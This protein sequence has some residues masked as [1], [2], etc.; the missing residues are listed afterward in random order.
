M[1]FKRSK[2]SKSKVKKTFFQA[3][4]L[5]N[6]KKNSLSQEENH[7]ISETLESYQKALLEKNYEQ[8][9]KC[10]EKCQGFFGTHLKQS[11]IEKF[12]KSTLGLVGL[13]CV[14]IVVRQMWFEFNEIPTGSM[15]PTLLEKDKLAV[16]KCQYG[17]NI[18]LLPKHFYFNP[19]DVKRSGVILFSG[20]GM[21]IA[22]V[23]TMHFY[24][25]PGVKQYIKR[26]IGKPGDIIYFYGGKLFGV[27]SQGQDISSELQVSSLSKIDHVPVLNF[28]GK[29]KSSK[30]NKEGLASPT[31][32][33]QYNKPVAKLRVGP[34]QNIYGELLDK[35]P[36]NAIKKYDDLFGMRN[37]A[38]A[39]L[40]TESEVEAHTDYPLT[41]AP[42]YLQLIHSPSLKN[43][44]IHRDVFTGNFRPHVGLSFSYLPLTES[45]IKTLMKNLYTSRFFVEKNGKVLPYNYKVHGGIIQK[46]LSL[47]QGTKV[48]YSFAPKLNGVASGTY[49]FYYGKAYKIGWGG[50]RQELSKEHPIYKYNL[51]NIRVL[52][53]LGIEWHNAFMP[54]NHFLRIYP[55][56][57]AYYRQGDLYVMGGKLFS[58]TDPILKTFVKEEHQKQLN[59][60]L[61]IPYTPF[62][63]I[64][65]PINEDGTLNIDFVKKHGIKVPE[66]HY[67]VLGDNYA[68][69]ADSRDFG[70]V[71]EGNLRGIG[72]FIFWPFGEKFGF[73][74]QPEYPI[75]T[76]SRIIVWILAAI[77]ISVT[78]VYTRRKHDLKRKLF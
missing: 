17:I 8:A 67:L 62:I 69:S 30:V 57:F 6:A 50:F 54:T 9:R 75:L 63:D 25:F 23:H 26:M 49:E 53:N 4:K 58:S 29:T 73:I 45:H 60:P 51:D 77:G 68:M 76:L 24:I 14:A 16:S 61:G 74:N 10:A 15:R 33:F 59:A 70:F 22:N 47:F 46:F 28:E 21:D 34:Y 3:V 64:G 2:L 37:Y 41:K 1:I 13:L 27:D 5:F 72:E 38:K 66:K 32:L 71:P 55:S 31:V 48:E 42:L 65:P 39:R 40:L 35:G 20:R 52:F 18:P 19:K 78:V 43:A 12:I 44:T 56:R 36:E 11:P 7:Q